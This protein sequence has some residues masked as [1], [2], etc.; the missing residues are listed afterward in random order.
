MANLKIVF[1]ASL[2]ET[3]KCDELELQIESELTVR[4]LKEKLAEQLQQ[5]LL[6]EEKVKAAIDFDFARDDD[7]IEPEKVREVAFFPPVTGG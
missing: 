2:R 1:F 5:P 3:M 4:Q 7:V 6:L